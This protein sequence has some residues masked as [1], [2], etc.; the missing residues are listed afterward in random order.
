M[1]ENNNVK[2]VIKYLE[3]L[4]IKYKIV[5][6]PPVYT[7]DE[8]DELDIGRDGDI[9][10]NLFLRDAKGKR[11]FLVLLHKDKKVDLKVFQEKLESTKLSFASEERLD[12][13]LNLTKGSVTPMGIIND[14]SKSV[15]VAIDKD[16]VGNKSLGVHPNDNTATIWLAFE[17]IV[18]VIESNGNKYTLMEM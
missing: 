8:M 6:H 15:E 18:K 5:E 10:K 1:S 7:I 2:K 12:K 16:L 14:E 3:S 13:Y 9:V 17:D 11:H 4:N